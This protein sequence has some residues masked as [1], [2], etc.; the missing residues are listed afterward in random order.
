MNQTAKN[1]LKKIQFHRFKFIWQYFLFLNDLRKSSIISKKQRCILPAIRDLYPCLKDKTQETYFD[2][3]Y[4]YH[5]GWAARTLKKINPEKH[6]DF[7]SSLYFASIASAFVPIKF[8]DYRPANLL[9][10]NLS[11]AS[12]DLL[13]LQISSNSLESV[14][15]MHVIEHIGAW[16]I[17]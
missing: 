10:P 1:I 15:C 16:T 17:W 2:R 7:S 9:L 14:S 13:S 12:A 5:T 6:V 8:Y 11:M 3:H 4:I